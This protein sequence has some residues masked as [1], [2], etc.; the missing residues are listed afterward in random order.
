MRDNVRSQTTCQ[1][2]HGGRKR[3]LDIRRRLRAVCRRL[4]RILSQFARRAADCGARSAATIASALVVCGGKVQ[5]VADLPEHAVA[6][7]VNEKPPVA[8]PRQKKCAH[9]A[10]RTPRYR[11]VIS[12]HPAAAGRDTRP[13]ATRR[14][15]P[16]TAP[17]PR[18][19]QSRGAS[20]E[21]SDFRGQPAHDSTHRNRPAGLAGD[22]RCAASTLLSLRAMSDVAEQ[23]AGS[24]TTTISPCPRGIAAASSSSS[25]IR[26]LTTDRSSRLSIAPI[27]SLY[28]R[29]RRG[30]PA[31]VGGQ[32]CQAAGGL[33]GGIPRRSHVIRS[34]RPRSRRARSRISTSASTFR[35]SIARA[36]ATRFGHV[37]SCGLLLD[38]HNSSTSSNFKTLRL[39]RRPPRRAVLHS[40]LTSVRSDD[41]P[42]A[43]FDPI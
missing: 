41:Q 27:R 5:F 4:R 43:A 23:I 16:R 31:H 22:R 33:N 37:V 17:P 6:N 20:A 34:S 38:D 28:I 30:D 32:L 1:S 19:P 26:S 36:F 2:L 14:R 29:R 35:R 12:R 11:D 18:P 24:L 10:A 15:R 25:P 42:P 21:I 9:R 8:R 40:L 7:L 39:A 13:I 3:I